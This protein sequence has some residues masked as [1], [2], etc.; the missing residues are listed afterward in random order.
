MELDYD[1]EVYNE[2]V[3]SLKLMYEGYEDYYY[4]LL[5]S[6]QPW[7]LILFYEQVNHILNNPKPQA[8]FTQG[9]CTSHV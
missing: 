2:V 5:Y 1:P 8:K 6:L 9:G 7:E 3:A 4:D